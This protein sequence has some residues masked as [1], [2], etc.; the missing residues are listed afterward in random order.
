MRYL[1]P[2]ILILTAFS[3][4]IKEK[5][6]E[7]EKTQETLSIKIQDTILN[8]FDLKAIPIEFHALTQYD[9]IKVTDPKTASELRVWKNKYGEL[10]AECDQKDQLIKKVRVEKDKSTEKEKSK[11]VVKTLYKYDKWTFIPWGVI[12]LYLLWKFARGRLPF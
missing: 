11:E 5:V 9:T 7:T 4:K 8:G 2:F 6:R 10:E 1:V 3:C 12:G